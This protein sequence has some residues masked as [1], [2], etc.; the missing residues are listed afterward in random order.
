MKS[1]IKHLKNLLEKEPKVREYFFKKR[2]SF[3]NRKK[4]FILDLKKTKFLGFKL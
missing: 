2:Y 1:V 3:F 4:P